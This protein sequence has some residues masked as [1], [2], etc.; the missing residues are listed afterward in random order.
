[1][2]Y[3]IP[4]NK[5]RESNFPWLH[6]PISHH[7]VSKTP[8]DPL[9]IVLF[10]GV[11]K[12]TARF[13]AGSSWLEHSEAAAIKQA[14]DLLANIHILKNIIRVRKSQHMI[15]FTRVQKPLCINFVRQFEKMESQG[16]SDGLESASLQYTKP[17]DSSWHERERNEYNMDTWEKKAEERREFR[18]ETNTKHFSYR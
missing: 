10:V 14:L 17:S 13:Q 8:R 9:R 5:A 2:T 7:N 1:M 15:T 12:K 16:N 18:R 11:R 4:H 6:T 3:P